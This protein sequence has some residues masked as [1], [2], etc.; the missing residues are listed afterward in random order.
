LGCAQGGTH[1]QS[2]FSNRV[3]INLGLHNN[4][5]INVEMNEDHLLKEDIVSGDF[6]YHIG[7][8]AYLLKIQAHCLK[9]KNTIDI[10][11]CI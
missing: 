11:L 8:H 1:L 5:G 6:A 7:L 3:V 2:F 4:K 10:T 9:A